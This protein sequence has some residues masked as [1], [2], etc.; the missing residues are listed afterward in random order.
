MLETKNAFEPDAFSDA[1]FDYQ[2]Y[3]KIM[4]ETMRNQ[5]KPKYQCSS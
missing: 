1:F 2:I 3:I 5:Q 4:N